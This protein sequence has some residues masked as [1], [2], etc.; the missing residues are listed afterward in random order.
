MKEVK[1]SDNPLPQLDSAQ[2][3]K[4]AQDLSTELER[5]KIQYD[6]YFQGLEKREPLKLKESVEKKVKSLSN[7]VVNSAAIKFKISQAIARFNSLNHVW[8]KFVREIEEGKFKRDMFH[9]KLKSEE[10][11]HP[12]SVPPPQPPAQN[13]FDAF[14][15]AKKQCGEPTAG[16]TP[17]LFERTLQKHKEALKEKAQNKK[18]E[19]KVVVE[20]G[21]P[22]LKAVIKA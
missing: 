11:P 13:L 10:H 21:K 19:F 5:L 1:K 6:L 7:L 14:I 18:I 17:E 15:Q 2:I 22:K 3:A 16:L 4:L 9:L 20:N 8:S 12:S